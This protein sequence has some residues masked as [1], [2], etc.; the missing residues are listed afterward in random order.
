MRTKPWCINA[1]AYRR[2]GGEPQATGGQLCELVVRAIQQGETAAAE[3]ELSK[4]AGTDAPSRL[5]VLL[6][7]LRAILEGN[8]DP[9][10]TNDPD[11]EYDDAAE[12]QLL[13]ERLK[14]G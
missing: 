3:Q 5:Q 11:L 14:T 6:A 12:L 7:K 2:D 1:L 13:L 8:R 9:T 10:L 4:Y